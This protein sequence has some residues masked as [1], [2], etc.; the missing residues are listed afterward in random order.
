MAKVKP[1]ITTRTLRK[2]PQ[3]SPSNDEKI[4]NLK[5][6][7]KYTRA[8]RFKFFSRLP[9]ELR[10]KIW[11]YAIPDR[12]AYSHANLLF[13]CVGAGRLGAVLSAIIPF[14]KRWKKFSL[15]EKKIWIDFERDVVFL[16]VWH[17]T[18]LEECLSRKLFQEF[19]PDEVSRIKRL[20]FGGGWA[21]ASGA[22]RTFMELIGQRGVFDGFTSLEE[23]YVWDDI[24]TIPP[25]PSGNRHPFALSDKEPFR[26]GLVKSLEILRSKGGWDAE[27]PLPSVRIMR[28]LDRV[29]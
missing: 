1:S 28:D 25:P 14:I 26:L 29:E 24:S 12:E 3:I 6:K 19:V 10:L 13:L 27:R 5:P 20:G 8:P 15:G 21:V 17:R 7:R 2:R 23:V 9:A 16:D 18:G 4:P 22:T 11:H